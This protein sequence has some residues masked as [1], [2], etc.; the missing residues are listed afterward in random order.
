MGHLVPLR[1]NATD[2]EVRRR[3]RYYVLQGTVLIV[4]GIAAIVLLLVHLFVRCV[5]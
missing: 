3:E 5:R 4:C 1:P 2:D